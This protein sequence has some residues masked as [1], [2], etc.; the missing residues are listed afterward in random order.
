[1]EETFTI[2]G[3]D[4][5]RNLG[6]TVYTVNLNFQIVR[7]NTHYLSTAN[8]EALNVHK[9]GCTAEFLENILRMY[10]PVIVAIESAF[11]GSFAKA[12]GS[13]TA[14]ITILKRTVVTTSDAV[15]LNVSPH[16]GKRIVNAAGTKKEDML[17]AI[18]QIQEIT[19]HINPIGLNE[20]V[21]D[22]LAVAYVG[23]QRIRED[24]SILWV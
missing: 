13:L 7:I 15:I 9:L 19:N 22:S 21:V 3:I 18:L 6:I 8:L 2:V 4:T 1:M 10:N 5:G 20:H 23:L 16:E 14:T 12:F 17:E 11:M 24:E